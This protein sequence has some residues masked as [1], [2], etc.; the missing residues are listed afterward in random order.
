MCLTPVPVEAVVAAGADV[1]VAVN[2][3]GRETLS[4]W[5]GHNDSEARL[6]S[7]QRDTVI[8]ALVRTP[9]E[10]AWCSTPRTPQYSAL[11][12]RGRRIP[13]NPLPPDLAT[14]RVHHGVLEQK[15]QL[16]HTVADVTRQS[17]A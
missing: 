3:L 9:R 12:H 15:L 14:A 11:D 2:I 10:V 5:P 16:D 13:P 4:R 8:E 7:Q 6:A 1:T 17:T